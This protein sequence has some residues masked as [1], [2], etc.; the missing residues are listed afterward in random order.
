LKHILPEL[1]WPT[2]YTTP[3]TLGLVKKTLEEYKTVNRLKYKI[4]DP[5]TELLK[6][7]CFSIEFVRVNHNIPE[8]FALAVQTPK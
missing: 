8:T 3:L 7:G 5:D 4:V 1:N 6:L 2:V